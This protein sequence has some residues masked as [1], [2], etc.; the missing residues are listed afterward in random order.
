MHRQISIE[1][2]K[3]SIAAAVSRAFWSLPVLALPASVFSGQLGIL[4]LSQPSV[5][6]LLRLP[7]RSPPRS[8]RT[9]LAARETR[10][11]VEGT[12]QLLG[13]SSPTRRQEKRS[14]STVRRGGKDRAAARP[15]LLNGAVGVGHTGNDAGT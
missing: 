6:H 10:A 15:L 13:T 9:L 11:K 14:S 12:S 3:L 7:R 5:A 2:P 1:R 4:P 8:L